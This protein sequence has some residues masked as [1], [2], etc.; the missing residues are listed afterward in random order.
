M[1]FGKFAGLLIAGCLA[2]GSAQA[3]AFATP[4]SSMPLA[5]SAEASPVE[6]AQYYEGRRGF[7]DDRGFRGP[8]RGNGYAYGRGYRGR[9]SCQIVTRRVYDP[10]IGRMRTVNQ[11]VC[12]RF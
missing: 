4:A 7:R 12:G 8:G 3:A 10:R 6:Q 1:K 11:R 9:P 2:A 5:L